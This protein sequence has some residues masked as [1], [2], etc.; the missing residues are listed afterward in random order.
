MLGIA[1]AAVLVLQPEVPAQA[2][3]QGKT[4]DAPAKGAAGSDWGLLLSWPVLLNLVFFILFS[5]ANAGMQ[6]YSLVALSALHHTPLAVANAALTGFLF[7]S[8]IGVL[9]G[10]WA[11]AQTSRYALVTT[12]G[13]VALTLV[14]A[15]VSGV[16]LHPVALV[17]AF[18]LGGFLFGMTM[19]PRDM[20]VREVTPPGSFGK[21]FGFVTTGFNIGGIFSPLVYGALMDHAAPRGVFLLVAAACVLSMATM[22]TGRRAARA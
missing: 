19:P 11:V 12:Q 21:V 8:A 22:A 17:A 16:D 14:T 13:L 1:V 6:S 7:M 9:A 15:L 3:P 5:V 20:L 2:G 4:R 18:S 10:G